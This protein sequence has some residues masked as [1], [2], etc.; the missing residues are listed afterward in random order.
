MALAAIRRRDPAAGAEEA[1]LR[2]IEL[3]YGAGLAGEVRRHL[4]KPSL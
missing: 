4:G 1:R 3:A 2:S